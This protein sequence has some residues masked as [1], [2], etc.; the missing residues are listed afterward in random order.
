MYTVFWNLNGLIANV[1]SIHKKKKE[2][3][4]KVFSRNALLDSY[5]QILCVYETDIQVF[6][7]FLF[8][9][10]SWNTLKQK[11]YSTE[12][13]SYRELGNARN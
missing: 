7:S 13:T 4:Y 9:F 12:V 1:S 10:Y 2:M 5:K 11:I 8:D 3:L 6:F